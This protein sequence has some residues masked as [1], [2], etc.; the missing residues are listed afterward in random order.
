[1]ETEIRRDAH[2]HGHYVQRQR[3]TIQL[4]YYVY[5]YDL[6]KRVLPAGRER[7]RALATA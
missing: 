5:E 7:A 2:R 4:D 3:H 1:M 6:R